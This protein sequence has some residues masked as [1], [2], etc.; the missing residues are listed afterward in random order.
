MNIYCFRL[1]VLCL[2]FSTFPVAA[3]AEPFFQFQTSNIQILRGNQYELGE[4]DRS[5]VTLEHAN[6]WKYGDNYGFIDFIKPDGADYTYYLELAPRLSLSKIT[7]K[8]ISFGIVKDILI[9]STYEKAKNRGP[10]YLIGPGVDLDIPTFKFFKVNGYMHDSTNLDGQTWQVTV[11]W[12][13]RFRMM[14]VG[15]LAEGFADF[16]G[17]EDTSHPNQLIVPRLLFDIGEVLDIG[18]DKLWM[19][20]E[21]QYWHN[22]FGLN[23]KTESVPQ[24]QMKWVF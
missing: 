17:K 4:K 12:N 14:G 20:M 23:G 10:Q 8:D 16:Q 22:K 5:I 6:V 13:N 3:Q 9:A 24:L 21:Y 15:T 7:G 11:A 2:A 19:G 18:D 1:S